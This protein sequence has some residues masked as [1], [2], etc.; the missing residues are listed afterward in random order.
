MNILISNPMYKAK[1][2]PDVICQFN[3]ILSK[4][5]VEAKQGIGK[6]YMTDFFS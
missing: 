1:G 3:L 5:V 4:L 6:P 2:K